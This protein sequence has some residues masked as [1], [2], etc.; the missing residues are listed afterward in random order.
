MNRSDPPRRA[1]GHCARPG[2][3]KRLVAGPPKTLPKSLRP[4]FMEALAREPFC[5]TVCC[6]EYYDNEA[7]AES[8]WALNYGASS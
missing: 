7:A 2:C 8:I 5:S 1:D 4:M 6:R 3:G